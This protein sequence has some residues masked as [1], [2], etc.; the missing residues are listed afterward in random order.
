M[1]EAAV[2]GAIAACTTL[3]EAEC[4]HFLENGCELCSISLLRA[5]LLSLRPASALRRSA[6]RLRSAWALTSP[7]S[8][9]QTSS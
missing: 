5:S 3:T 2:E 8:V 4:R 6:A 1:S 9:R 7:C